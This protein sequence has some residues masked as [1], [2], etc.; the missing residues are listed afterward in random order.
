[1]EHVWETERRSDVV[2]VHDAVGRPRSITRNTIH[3]TLERLVRKGLVLRHR[4]GRA[5]HYAA[6]VSRRD[7]IAEMLDVVSRQFGDE[8]HDAVLAG[9]VDFAARTGEESLSS[10]E[11]M[12]L[13]RRRSDDEPE[14][15]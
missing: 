11:A 4:E 3:S 6:S 8:H 1:M 9:F 7:W 2:S 5:Y 13:A 14:D 10:L 15:D 12:V